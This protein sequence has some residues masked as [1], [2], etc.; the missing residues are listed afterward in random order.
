MPPNQSMKPPSHLRYASGEIQTF[1]SSG[2]VAYLCLVRFAA[3]TFMTLCS[4]ALMIFA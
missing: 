4:A 3:K 1:P 2:W